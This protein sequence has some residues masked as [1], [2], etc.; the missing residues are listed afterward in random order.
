MQAQY[1][2]LDIRGDYAILVDSQGAQNPVA[3]ALL[4][5]EIDVGQTVLWENFT[6]RIV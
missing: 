1:T 2:V 3:L 5:L 6:Y 4:P